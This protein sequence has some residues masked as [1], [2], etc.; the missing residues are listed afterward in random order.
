[1]LDKQKFRPPQSPFPSVWQSF[2]TIQVC[3]DHIPGLESSCKKQLTLS[4][5]SFFK[6][7]TH[8]LNLKEVI[9]FNRKSDD[10]CKTF[11]IIKKYSPFS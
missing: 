7:E 2:I 4:T 9:K 11:L 3:R 8:Q 1:M 10:S 6:I 5:Y